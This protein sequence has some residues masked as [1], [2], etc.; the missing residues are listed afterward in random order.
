VNHD[1]LCPQATRSLVDGCRCALIARVRAQIASEI[2][3]ATPAPMDGTD[4]LNT[5]ISGM[6]EA[7]RIARGES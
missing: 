1:D 3:A 6:A 2:G 4:Y 7:A 5:Y